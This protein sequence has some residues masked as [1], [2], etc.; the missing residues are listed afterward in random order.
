MVFFFTSLKKC[1]TDSSN[2]SYKPKITQKTP[3]LTPGRIAPIPI[4]IPTK[5]F[6]KK[7]PSKIYVIIVIFITNQIC[8]KLKDARAY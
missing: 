8:R 4:K 2:F 6:F 1:K 5:K 7:S 3:L